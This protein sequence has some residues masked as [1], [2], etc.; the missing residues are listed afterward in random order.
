MKRIFVAGKHD[1]NIEVIE[2]D[3]TVTYKLYYSDNT[4]WNFPNTFITKIIDNGSGI[5]L[6]PVTSL[7]YSDAFD[8]HI[9]LAYIH[10][11][12]KFVDKIEVTIEL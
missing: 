10:K 6:M 7:D 3:D 5:D 2:D 4:H 9:L 11:T 12:A 1:Y 8:L